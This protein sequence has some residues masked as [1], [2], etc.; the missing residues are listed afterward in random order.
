MLIGK[1]PI[2]KNL[3]VFM[4]NL[5]VYYTLQNQKILLYLVQ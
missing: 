3:F 5:L 1:R 2:E 4:I